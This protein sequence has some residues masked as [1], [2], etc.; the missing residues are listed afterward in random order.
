MIRSMT[1]FASREFQFAEERLRWDIKSINHR[2][3]EISFKLPDRLQELESTLRDIVRHQLHR[4]KIHCTLSYAT[5]SESSEKFAINWPLCTE[6]YRATQEIVDRYSLVNP[7]SAFDLLKWPNVIRLPIS[8]QDTFGLEI[9]RSFSA[10]MNEVV[11][12]R[13]REGEDLKG[14]LEQ[15]LVKMSEL[16][17]A[18]KK[19]L[20]KTLSLYREKLLNRINEFKVEHDPGRLEQEML[21]IAQKIDV[22]EELDRLTTHIKATQLLLSK[23]G[24]IGRQLDF[25]MQEFNRETNTLASKSIDIMVTQAT[26]EMKVLIEQMR[27]QVQN[28]E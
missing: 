20:P 10:L 22:S 6:I 11:Q 14:F 2:Y 28:I 9:T 27:E 18:I 13:L 7:I 1:A 15:R 3:L 4:G 12:A 21:F 24:T 23:G 5:V 19:Q 26:I 16:V 17:N 8:E 25:L